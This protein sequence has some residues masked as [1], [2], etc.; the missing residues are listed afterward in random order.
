MASSNEDNVLIRIVVARPMFSP[1]CPSSL[2]PIFILYNGVVK[3]EGRTVTSDSDD[4]W[5]V[6]LQGQSQVFNLI[7]SARLWTEQPKSIRKKP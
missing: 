1:P 3:T 5:D 4:R 2:S 6:R 7:D